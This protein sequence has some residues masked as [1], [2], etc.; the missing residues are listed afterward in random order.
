[1]LRIPSKLD[2]LNKKRIEDELKDAFDFDPKDPL[3]GL[4][5]NEMCGSS[6]NRRTV[7][8]LM[9]AAGAL[10]LGHLL[11]GVGASP[12]RAAKRGGHLRAAWSGVDE[13]IT[14]DPARM[15][16]VVQFQI[17]SNVLS[18]L[19]HIDANLVAQ[20]D[21]ASGWGVSD[22]GRE[23]TFHLRE[24]MTFHNGDPFTADDVVFTYNRSKDPKKSIHSRVLSNVNDVVKVDDYT[25]KMILGA[26]QASF[27]VKTLERSSG[28]AM[29]LVSRGALE[30]MGDAQYGLTPVGTGPFKITFHELGQGVVLE[31]N[32]NYY[33]PDRPVLDKVTIMPIADTEAIGA[34][35]E[36]GDVD[37]IGGGSPA[38]E[39]IDRFEANSDLV[40]ST[41]PGPSFQAV[42]LNPHRDPFRVTDFNKPIDDL[43]KESG[44]KVRLAIA[45][46]L[47][48]ARYLERAQ[49]GRGVPAYGSINPAMGFYFDPELGSTSPQRFE[50][51][52]ARRLLAEAG[53]PDGEGFPEIKFLH[54]PSQ[55]REVQIIAD[56]FKRV[57]NIEVALD[58]KDPNVSWEDFLKMDYDLTL[59]GS[60]GDFDPDDAI[61]DWMQTESKFN[62]P[63]RDKSK[64]AFGYFSEKR[65]DDLVDAQRLETD[66]EKRKAMVQEANWIHSA[67]VAC[68]FLY[69]R[70]ST[71]VYRKTLIYPPESRIP[72]LVELDRISFV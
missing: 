72:G 7:L 40:V 12:A 20:P 68:A 61:V 29:T 5:R 27:M 24:G 51:E 54:D 14:L 3:F 63:N 6:L 30:S 49:F 67:K 22:D 8:R 50:P 26:P 62:G 9:A 10:T 33:D 39:L 38:A 13:L 35:I 58:T 57:L 25:V 65:A 18:G 42:W 45:K 16:E 15:N 55:R 28:R 2:S 36:A 37:L 44:F 70:M 53:Y 4:N 48:R 59:T 41:V 64:M 47:D 34:A 52:E 60:G 56:I 69:H 66:L 19:T 1:M 17:T 71:L 21:A 11:P 43:L 32:E 46:A 31:R 23:Y